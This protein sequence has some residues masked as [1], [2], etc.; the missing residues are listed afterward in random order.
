MAPGPLNVQALSLG[1]VW[2]PRTLRTPV[3]RSASRRSASVPWGHQGPGGPLCPA[4]RPGAQPR[5][6]VDTEDPEDPCAP[7]SVQVLSLSSVL[8]PGFCGP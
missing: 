4:Q 5:F 1:S 6:R 8:T 3:L 2:T 7:L